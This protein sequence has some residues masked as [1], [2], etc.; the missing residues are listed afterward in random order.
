[1]QTLTLI[2][3]TLSKAHSIDAGLDIYSAEDCT[4]YHKDHRAIS[5]NLRINLPLNHF[6]LVKPRSGLSFNH[7]IETGAGV[8]DQGYTGE[9]KVKLY[10]NSDIPFNISKGQAIAQL[11][12][13]PMP[14]I[15]VLVKN[16]NYQGPKEEPRLAN[17]FGSSDYV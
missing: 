10:N 4:V 6:A 16:G 11:V 1:M 2:S 14:Q 13:L 12:I 3:G 5:T 9:I 7:H 15:E 17:G 8:I